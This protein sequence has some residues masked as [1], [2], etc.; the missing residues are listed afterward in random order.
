MFLS[1]KIKRY[2]QDFIYVY[3][4]CMHSIQFENKTVNVFLC[5]LCSCLVVNGKCLLQMI[6]AELQ[7]SF[8]EGT[9]PDKSRCY[10]C[11][12]RLLALILTVRRLC[13]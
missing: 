3:V 6:M 9:Y 2:V 10:E 4:V 12:V 11:G 7:I 8:A 5:F 13:D 1:R